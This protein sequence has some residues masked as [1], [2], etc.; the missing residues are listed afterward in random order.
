MSEVTI[1][2]RLRVR[3]KDLVGAATEVE[4]LSA[5]GARSERQ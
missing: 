2:A 3:M 1:V 4:I 5:L